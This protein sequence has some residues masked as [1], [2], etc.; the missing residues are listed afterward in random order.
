M[1]MDKFLGNI[2][3]NATLITEYKRKNH[4]DKEHKC[5]KL[6]TRF[7]LFGIWYIKCESFFVIAQYTE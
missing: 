7:G 1:Q 3:I 2:V 4:E 5:D 6:D